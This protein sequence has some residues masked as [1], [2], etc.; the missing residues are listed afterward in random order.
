M[1]DTPETAAPSQPYR[2][3]VYLDDQGRRVSHL[4]PV[5]LDCPVLPGDGPERFVGQAVFAAPDGVKAPLEFPLKAST[6]AEAFA[7]YDTAKL[8]MQELFIAA[9]QQ[10]QT[11]A[12]L[13]GKMPNGQRIP[14]P[15]ILR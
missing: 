15:R 1:S 6:L 10:A 7:A 4:T 12:L 2:E 3:T 9:M 8:L 11:R 14:T 5:R 13:S